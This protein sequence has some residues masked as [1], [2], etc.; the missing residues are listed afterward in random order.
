[1]EPP[2]EEARPAAP[3]PA[4][5]AAGRATGL[6]DQVMDGVR[7]AAARLDRRL[8]LHKPATSAATAFAGLASRG[9]ALVV[10]AL[11]IV[12]A[13]VALGAAAGLVGS[14]VGGVRPT[15]LAEFL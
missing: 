8:V 11:A 4:A 12:A 3:A 13:S 1:M 10:D 14:L 5:D 2:G 15:W 7:H 9:T 6:A